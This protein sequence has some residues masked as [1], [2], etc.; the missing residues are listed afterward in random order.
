MM[1][2]LRRARRCSS[3]S[4]RVCSILLVRDV[5]AGDPSILM[6]PELYVIAAALSAGLFVGVTARTTR[7]GDALTEPQSSPMTTPRSRSCWVG[8]ARMSCPHARVPHAG[9]R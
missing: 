3:G 7:P 5:L 1:R 6:R 2:R 8:A 9:S 4:L